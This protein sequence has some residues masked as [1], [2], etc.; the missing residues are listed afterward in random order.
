MKKLKLE[1]ADLAFKIPHKYREEK[2]ARKKVKLLAIKLAAQGNR[3]AI[4]I[5]EI[6]DCSRSS[7]FEWIKSFRT[8]GFQGLLEGKKPG[9][10]R[11]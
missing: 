3:T 6:C 2:N 10:R 11:G 5:A 1:R 8:G 9:P 7:I 4:E